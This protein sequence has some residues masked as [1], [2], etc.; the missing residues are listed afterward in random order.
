MRRA[1]TQLILFMALSSLS[2]SAASVVRAEPIVVI[3]G[4][5]SPVSEL[6][7]GDLQRI[8]LSMP[9]QN[10]QGTPFVPFNYPAKTP[11]R[12]RFD[13]IILGMSPDDVGRHWIDQRIRGNPAPPRTMQ[14][15]TLLCRVVAKVQ[16]A[17][18]YIPASLLG[19]QCQTVT[20]GGRKL[21]DPGYVFA[22]QG[23]VAHVASGEA[24][25]SFRHRGLA[26]GASKVGAARGAQLPRKPRLLQAQ[27]R[28]RGRNSAAGPARAAIVTA[29]FA[30]AH[31]ALLEQDGF[32]I[33]GVEP[34]TLAAVGRTSHSLTCDVGVAVARIGLIHRDASS[35]AKQ[36]ALGTNAAATHDH[37]PLRAGHAAIAF[38]R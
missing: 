23:S 34:R 12:E 35:I 19:P 6:S 11:V 30:A 33:V 37:L 3:V 2:L 10:A 36:C 8:F 13:R 17:I 4:K 32:T 27:R 38:E 26:A 21:M 18:A 7:T 24:R 1:H 5:G 16:G 29:H 31:E 15:P 25:A 20:I 14:S 22:A 28:A 9:M